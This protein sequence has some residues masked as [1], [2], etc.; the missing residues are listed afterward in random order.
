MNIRVDYAAQVKLAAGV[1]SEKVELKEGTSL[2][3]LLMQL[4]M[5]RGDGFRKLLFGEDGGIRSSILL[6]VND[7]QVFVGDAPALQAGDVVAVL[8]PMSGG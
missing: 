6:S 8:S 4:A 7:E 3:D 1:A 5:Q 2:K